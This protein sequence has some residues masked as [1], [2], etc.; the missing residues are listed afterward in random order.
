MII[1]LTQ[2]FPPRL[3]G[4]ESLMYNLSLSLA[5]NNKVLVLAD[6]HDSKKDNFFDIKIKEKI[7]IQRVNG[8][9]FLRR[10]KK[11]KL[12]KS[13]VDSNDV[14]VVIGDSWKS[15]ELAVEFLNSSKISTICLAHG[16]ELIKKNN[17]QF[18]RLKITLNRVSSIVCNSN[19]TKTLLKQ[20]HIKTPIIK[21][22]YPGAEDLS[23]VKEMFIPNVNGNPIL[24]TLSRLERRKGHAEVVLSVAKLKE[25]F[26][27]IQYIIAGTGIE[28][29][30]LKESVRNLNLED[31][32]I[33]VGNVNNMQKNYLLNRTTLM[34]MPTIDKTSNRSIEGFGISYIEASFFSVPSIASNIGGTS[35]AVLHN[36]TGIVIENI[37]DLHDNLK[38]LLSDKIFLSKLGKKAQERARKDFKWKIVI[39]EYLKLISELNKS[40]S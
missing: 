12:L 32:V 36:K 34:V 13:V 26:P 25:Q 10:R 4:I 18:N 9:K 20:I 6:G 24:L 7:E 1:I 38:L 31:N 28:S 23:L 30:K 11:I 35:E 33:F 19:F 16:N 14:S 21:R 29:N 8:L 39:K 17:N 37:E 22:I 5:E 15:F 3:G 27:N 2:C 40:K